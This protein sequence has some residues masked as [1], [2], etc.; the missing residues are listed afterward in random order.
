[1]R[2]LSLEDD[3]SK[4]INYTAT[5]TNGQ[6]KWGPPPDWTGPPPPKGTEVFVTR[7]PRDCLEG[8][9][10]PIFN[11]P[12]RIYI[13]RL[14]MDFSGTNRGFGFV[15]YSTK[16]EAK[17]AILQL[18]GYE[19]QPGQRIRVNKSVDNCRLF[20]GQIPKDL[21]KEAV[22]STVSNYVSGAKD[23]IMYFSPSNKS[24]NRGFCFVE[25]DSHRSAA[26]ARR[27]FVTTGVRLWGSCIRVDWAVPEEDPN[28]DIMSRV[29]ACVS[30]CSP[31]VYFCIIWTPF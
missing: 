3:S 28:D 30:I 20:I 27:F 5:Q 21:T 23:V 11:R 14:M 31:P 13:F 12:G 16:A 6:R 25:F 7:L 2:E 15:Q 19:I 29:F 1:M 22:I 4:L 8:E 17:N 26:V 24:F 10:V 18:D 9:L